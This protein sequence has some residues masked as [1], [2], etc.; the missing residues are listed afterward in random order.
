L[1][2]A[3]LRVQNSDQVRVVSKQAQTILVTV[4]ATLIA[5][6]V[7][8]NIRGVTLRFI[9]WQGNFS[10]AVLLP[11]VFFAGALAGWFWRRRKS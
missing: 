9:I 6:L 11:A 1:A 7:L 3:L 5:I 2:A 8:Q 4:L 10:L